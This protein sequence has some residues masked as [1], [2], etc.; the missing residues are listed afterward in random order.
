MG[1]CLLLNALIRSIRTGRTRPSKDEIPERNGAHTAVIYGSAPSTS[2]AKLKNG[3]RKDIHVE[4]DSE[5]EP[6][7]QHVADAISDVKSH[8]YMLQEA[9]EKDNEHIQRLRNENEELRREL[10]EK[11]RLIETLRTQLRVNA[12]SEAVTQG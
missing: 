8:L 12:G 9:V 3:T 10:S 2:E 11:D 7:E 1:D 4:S 5:Y 6:S